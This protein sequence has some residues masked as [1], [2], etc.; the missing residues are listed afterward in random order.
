MNVRMISKF[1][2]VT[3][4]LA[5]F[6]TIG[7]S[8]LALTPT[9][10]DMLVASDGEDGDDF[11][12]SVVVDG[13]TVVIGAWD[14]IKVDDDYN[15]IY[16]SGS[17]YVFIRD[18]AGNWIEQ[19][20][21]LPSR[22]EDLLGGVKFGMSVSLSGDTVVIGS[23]TSDL[24]YV[25][26]RDG[27]GSWTEQA[28]LPENG[29]SVSVDGDTVV[30]GRRNQSV[31]SVYV[32]ISGSW[33]NAAQLTASDY[34]VSDQF[35]ESVSLD[36]DTVVIGAS[37]HEN[38]AAY[39]F[40][41]DS[42]TSGIFGAWTEQ[43]KFTSSETG[44][45]GFGWPVAVDGDTA[46]IGQRCYDVFNSSVYVFVRDGSGLWTEQTKL[47]SSDALEGCWGF[48]K[49]ISVDGD[50]AVVG[51]DYPY[52]TTHVFVR[53]GSGSWAEQEGLT[54]GQANGGYYGHSV[55]L[56]GDTAVIGSPDDYGAGA[57]FIFSLGINANHPPAANAGENITISN[58]D[59]PSTIIQGVVTDENLD[60]LL[61]CRWIEGVVILLD[62]FPAGING[63]CPLNLNTTSLGAGTH[64]L[65][66]EVTDGQSTSSDEMILT[67]DNCPNISNP[68]QEDIDDDGIGD[69]CDTDIDIKRTKIKWDKNKIKVHGEI[70]LPVG[71]TYFDLNPSSTAI[72]DVATLAGTVNQNVVFEV[73]GDNGEK[74]EYKSNTGGVGIKK[75]K[76]NWKGSKFDYKQDIHLKSNHIGQD[77]STLEIDPKD[78]T[79]ALSITVE[80]VVIQIDEAGVVI[81]TPDTIEIDVDEGSEVEVELP[82][83]LTPDTIFYVTQE[84]VSDY[85]VLVSDY[86]TAGVGKFK[87]K[88]RF[89]SGAM[90]GDV[91]PATFSLELTLGELDFPGLFEIFDA[92]WDKLTDSKWKYKR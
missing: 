2:L 14:D 79:G 22:T 49:S 67:I 15:L 85:E 31:V 46:M 35:G 78:V 16:N 32:R 28:R 82:F 68:G 64:T 71:K 44:S 77:T 24:V 1:I 11:G 59:I 20:K 56:N 90:N 89:D 7:S 8:V 40:V 29:D 52:Q 62:W 34:L 53:D 10:V 60:D 5:L 87:I 18:G 81:V 72:I 70:S 23:L 66:L 80:N 39:V 13:D 42:S 3:F 58:V 37:G 4:I 61:E 30:I 21:L 74:W 47:T 25:F 84:G 9:F 43:A 69:H 17:A 88:A 55:S 51:T 38:G 73:K 48:G 63:G 83:A 41:R 45:S 54:T 33:W 27:S 92:D 65:T 57:A 75:Y 19:T 6:G 91:R 86:Y 36:G 26:I 76:I 50:T 12:H